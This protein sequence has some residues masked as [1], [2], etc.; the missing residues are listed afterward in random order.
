MFAK[1]GQARDHFHI[2]A[3]KNKM[4]RK[5]NKTKKKKNPRNLDGGLKGFSH[6]TQ[7]H[8]EKKT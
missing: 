3:E 1:P 2:S 7:T 4:K 5:K 8:M 6:F